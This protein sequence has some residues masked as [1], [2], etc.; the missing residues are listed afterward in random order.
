M[1]PIVSAIVIL[2]LLAPP[3]MPAPPS[4]GYVHGD[5]VIYLGGSFPGVKDGTLGKLNTGSDLALVFEHAGGK[6]EIP[7]KLIRSFQY[8]EK[9]ARRLGAVL[10]VAVVLLKHRRRRHI[11]Q[12]AYYDR[13]GESRAAVFE[14]SKDKALPVVAVLEARSPKPCPY[15]GPNIREDRTE[16]G[17]SC[18]IPPQ[19]AFAQQ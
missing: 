6:A 3:A 15:N 4:S 11:I 18:R 7:Y 2:S 14:V 12:I 1:K 10:T 19:V 5:E 16:E 17:Q 9:L 13:E 8:Q